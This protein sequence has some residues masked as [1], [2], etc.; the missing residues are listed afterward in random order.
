MDRNVTV[1]S[2]TYE[3]QSIADVGARGNYIS[4]TSLRHLFFFRC[5]KSACGWTWMGS[6]GGLSVQGEG[7][8]G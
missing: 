6:A 1:A 4:M 8:G 5:V 3:D 7:F 2:T